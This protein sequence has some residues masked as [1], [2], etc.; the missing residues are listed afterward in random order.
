[1]LL[2]A[3]GL[4]SMTDDPARAAAGTSSAQSQAGHSTEL[5]E[6]MLDSLA[7]RF[8]QSGLMLAVFRPDGTLGYADARAAGFFKS[9][10][11]SIIPMCLFPVI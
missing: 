1:M 4:T 7:A 3:T 5:T 8:R 6:T 10:V 9:Y 11:V 2:N